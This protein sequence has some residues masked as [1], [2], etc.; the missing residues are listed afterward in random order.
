[1]ILFKEIKNNPTTL[2]TISNQGMYLHI[3]GDWWIFGEID[4]YL[5]LV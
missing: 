5:N 2:L 4:P 3:Q 1:M